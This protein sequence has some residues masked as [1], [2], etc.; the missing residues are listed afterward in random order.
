VHASAGDL[1]EKQHVYALKPQRVD[2]EEI[3]RHQTSRLRA[4]ELA[5]SRSRARAHR[6]KMYFAQELPNGRRGHRNPELS[7]AKIG[8]CKESLRPARSCN[9]NVP[10][11]V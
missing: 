7:F 8:S 2:G 10:S 5:P 4:D 3:H 1:D 6:P 9:E 11:I